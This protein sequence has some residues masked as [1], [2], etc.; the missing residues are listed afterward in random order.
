MGGQ[1]T[2]HFMASSSEQWIS[3]TNVSSG[4]EDPLSIAMK[5]REKGASK[6]SLATSK[7]VSKKEHSRGKGHKANGLTLWSSFQPWDTLSGLLLTPPSQPFLIFPRARSFCGVSCC[8]SGLR[9]IFYGKVGFF[10]RKVQVPRRT[11]MQIF[12]LYQ[13]SGV[14]GN[15]LCLKSPLNLLYLRLALQCILIFIDSSNIFLIFTYWTGR[16]GGEQKSWL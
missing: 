14:W 11:Y 12:T 7:L 13:A 6:G 9:C 2:S 5:H 8:S 3:R 16:T 15:L 4:G 10:W 1:K